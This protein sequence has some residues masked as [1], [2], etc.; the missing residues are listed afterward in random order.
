MVK[1]ECV[2]LIDNITKKFNKNCNCYSDNDCSSDSDSSSEYDSDSSCDKVSFYWGVATSSFQV[3]GAK[4][5]IR[6]ETIWDVFVDDVL[7]P[8][9]PEI[10]ADIACNSFY[11]Y[12][13]DI[14][15]VKKLGGNSYRFSIAWSRIFPKRTSTNKCDIGKQGVKYYNNVINYCLNNKITPFVTLY[16]WDL[17]QYLEIEVNGWLC[18]LT[19]SK[20]DIQKAFEIYADTCFKLFGDRVKHWSTINE[21]Q[22]ITTNCYEFN[23]YAPGV[24]TSDGNSIYGY[25]YTVGHNLLLSH[26]YAVKLYREKYQQQQEGKIGIVCNMDWSEPYTT[27]EEDKISAENYNIF[28]LGWFYDPIFFGDY[29]DIMKELVGDRLPK[30]TDYEKELVQGS[31]DLFYLNSYSSGYIKYHDYSSENLVGWYYDSKGERL[32]TN[33]NGE[34]I[35]AQTQSSW[36]YIV[37]WGI[38]KILLWIQNRYSYSGA[39]SGIGIKTKNGMKKIELIITEQGIDILGQD[40]DSTYNDCK[41]DDQRYNDYYSKYLQNI[42]LASKECGINFTGY[43]P[44]SLLD[45]F[46]WASGYE[47]RFGLFYLDCNVLNK[48][49]KIERKP[50][51]SVAWFNRYIKQNPNGPSIAPYNPQR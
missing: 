34:Y 7:R 33:S 9:N 23:W 38:R 37:P 51:N 22:T 50:K 20:N 1:T 24:G 36:L 11:Q 41:K 5:G 42:A 28:W 29:P 13:D 6:G 31:I 49:G 19:N 30:F 14:D 46:E 39:K 26:G 3:E 4:N 16:H 2:S 43:F 40:A 15:C 12:K 8:S 21:P 10:N 18:K 32:Y 25:E 27:S 47:C 35:G 45:N 17:P 44:W 48:E